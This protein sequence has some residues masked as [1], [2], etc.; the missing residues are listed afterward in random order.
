MYK[1]TIKLEN[2][3]FK[4]DAGREQDALHLLIIGGTHGNESNAVKIHILPLLLSLKTSHELLELVYRNLFLHSI[5]HCILSKLKVCLHSS[6]IA[7]GVMYWFK[8]SPW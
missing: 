5:V 4:K 3:W 1:Q 2:E 8:S 7:E 6:S